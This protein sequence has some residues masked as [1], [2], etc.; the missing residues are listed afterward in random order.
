MQHFITSVVSSLSSLW[1]SDYFL[2]RL[3]YAVSILSALSNE[4]LTC[5]MSILL[6]TAATA[7]LCVSAT[8]AVFP[9]SGS[10]W[11]ILQGSREDPSIE[12]VDALLPSLVCSYYLN[13]K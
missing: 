11:C 7:D 3:L 5:P 9:N 8:G 10:V 1:S 12:V 13:S 4:I 2:I 6:Q